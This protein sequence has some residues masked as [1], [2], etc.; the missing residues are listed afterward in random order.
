MVDR[1]WQTVPDTDSL[2]ICGRLGKRFLNQ[3]NHLP[4][5]I[6][7]NKNIEGTDHSKS[8]YAFEASVDSFKIKVK[9]QNYISVRFCFSGR[10]TF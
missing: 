10:L 9:S 8:V 1:P 6:V 5:L 3:T 7:Y 2:V 4:E